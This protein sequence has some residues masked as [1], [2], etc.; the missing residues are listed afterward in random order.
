MD[1]ISK[2]ANIDANMG[3]SQRKATYIKN[4]K[5]RES[6][7]INNFNDIYDIR[8]QSAELNRSSATFKGIMLETAEKNLNKV[9][10]NL[11]EIGTP[12]N[13]I[14]SIPSEDMVALTRLIIDKK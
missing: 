14:K 9:I 13:L 10:G 4:N 3:E 6:Q 11:G 5:N 8:L 2:V 7:I 1:N 12:D